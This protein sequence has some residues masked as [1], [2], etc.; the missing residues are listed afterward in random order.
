MSEMVINIVSAVLSIIIG[1]IVGFI[2]WR[3]LDTLEVNQRIPRTLTFTFPV[4]AI[5]FMLV[6]YL[7][8]YFK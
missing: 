3:K 1:G 2:A 5:V 8:R 6:W 4:M 7:A